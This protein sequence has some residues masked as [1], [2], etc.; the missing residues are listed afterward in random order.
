MLAS[1]ELRWRRSVRIEMSDDPIGQQLERSR[2]LGAGELGQGG[3][4]LTTSGG[5]Y[6]VG[7]RLDVALIEFGE[8]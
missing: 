7:Q 5:P 1:I 8:G 6:R 3:I 4:Y 2:I